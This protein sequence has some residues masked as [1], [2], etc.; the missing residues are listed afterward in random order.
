MRE[1]LRRRVAPRPRH[2]RRPLRARGEPR[3]AAP[4]DE[5]RFAAYVAQLAGCRSATTSIDARR[6]HGPPPARTSSPAT[7]ARGASARG[8]RRSSSRS[9]TAPSTRCSRCAATRARDWST[10]LDERLRVIEAALDRIAVRAPERVTEQRDRLRQ[11]GARAD[12]RRGRGRAPPRAGDRPPRRPARRARRSSRAFAATSRRSAPRSARRSRTASASGS[13][14]CSRRCSARRTRPAARGTTRAIVADVLPGE[15]GARADPR[16]GGEPRV[17][18]LPGHPQR[19]RAGAGRRPSPRRCWRRRP[20][21]GYSVSCTTRAP[22]PGEVPGR[23]Y[24]FI[25]RAE[26][27][28]EAGAGRLRRIGGGARQP[29]RHAAARGGAGA[30]ARDGTS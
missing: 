25:S 10:Y 23:D 4:I 14:S 12:R 13:A 30:G 18:P 7:R 2:A 28:A 17:S 15:G 19:A 5:A 24:Y 1:A 27:I 6:R 8:R 29:V 9:S 20:D 26:F 21:L 11:R 22:R 3:P 16:A